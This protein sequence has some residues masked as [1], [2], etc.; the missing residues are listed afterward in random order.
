MAE[1]TVD[2]PGAL[3]ALRFVAF[4]DSIT[5]GVLSSFDGM[6]LFDGSSFSYTV[7]LERDL[8]ANHRPQQFVVIN[9]GVP[10]EDVTF[11]GVR[12]IASVL[13]SDRPHALLLLEGINDLSGDVPV[14][15]IAAALQ[16]I[17]NTSVQRGVP[18]LLATMYQTYAVER[19]DGELRTN[20]A[21]LVP[22]LN[23]RI[24]QIATQQNVYLVDLYPAFGTNQD[25]VGGDGLHPTEEGY[26]VMATTF[27]RAIERAYPVRGSFQ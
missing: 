7:R 4:G 17:V 27:R 12:R 25:Y 15:Q 1:L 14:S 11:S 26:A 9:R 3:G 22:A 21:D 13:T 2:P 8:N 20:G 23:Q 16:S 10:A 24:R 18:V 6:A 5:Y 19:P